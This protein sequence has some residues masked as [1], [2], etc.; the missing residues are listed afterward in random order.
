MKRLL[1]ALILG[2][3][4]LASAQNPMFFQSA[5]S[6]ATVSNPTF[7]PSS[8]YTGGA[9]TVTI[10][11]GSTPSTGQTIYYCVT[12]TTCT[13]STVYT[14]GISFSSTENIFAYASAS[15]YNNSATVEWQGTYVILSPPT[16]V[17]ANAASCIVGNVSSNT[18]SLSGVVSGHSL[19]ALIITATSTAPS[20]VTD[21]GTNMICKFGY[22]GG[23]AA[24]MT[25]CTISGVASGAHSVTANWSSGDGGSS[26]M[27]VT[28]Y[29][30]GT[31]DQTPP[32]G[33]NGTFSTTPNCPTYT[34][35]SGNVTLISGWATSASSYP[36]APSGFT[37]RVQFQD[38]TDGTI[39]VLADNGPTGTVTPG[40]SVTPMWSGTNNYWGCLVTG[41]HP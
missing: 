33:V 23:N 39:I 34:T 29:T 21:N 9:T 25:I 26:Q 5:Y 36:T 10:T 4:S 16:F 32:N 8:P 31:L 28:E 12:T 11:Q 7:S 19:T 37:S 15:G 17:Q 13:P 2:F 40:T 41:I 18:C 30:A 1:A 6:T 14:T 22:A 35:V 27:A 20:S 38:T 24:G 3:A